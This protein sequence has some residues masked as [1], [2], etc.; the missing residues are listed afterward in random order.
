MYDVYKIRNDFPM[1]R[2]PQTMQGHPLVFL[3]NASTTFKPDRVLDAMDVYN[4]KETA[5]SHRG[6]YDLCNK[7]DRA[8]AKARESVARFL[9][10]GVNEIVFTAGATSALNLVAYGYCLKVLKPGDEILISLAEHASNVLP[11]FRIAS[12][13][14][15]K[16]K[17]IPL[18]EG[19]RITVEAVKTALTPHT[20]FV[21]VAYVGN[22]LGYIAPIKEIA[23]LAHA[24]GAVL[25]VDGA[26]STPHLKTDVKD[27]D[28]DFLAFSGHK[29]C[30]PTGTGALYGKY[31]LLCAMDP[32]ETGGGMNVKFYPDGT[33]TYL[34]PPMKFEA[35]TL[36]VAGIIGLG[37]AVEYVSSIGLEE[38]SAHEHM[39]KAYAV[40]KLLATGMVDIY[41]AD[42][43]GGIVTFNV[44]GVFSQDFATYL[45]AQGIACRS[46]QHCAKMLND[47]LCVPAT[48]RASFYLYTTKEEID[49]LVEA[50]KH[51]G[52]FLDAYF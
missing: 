43:E 8:V 48:V 51:G 37:E 42:S 34:L 12:L 15:A 18:S 46:G 31:D 3:D 16:V 7:A 52:N 33:A 39:L 24:N 23:A 6:D 9:N 10:A 4:R 5:N 49:A 25:C 28:C 38:I 41:N 50:V 44:H 14:G 11:W 26:Q 47:V 17:Y 30:A 22:V 1:L 45:N 32:F 29:F 19:N 27:L 13:T 21:S 36:N 40:E 35:G 20:K 2:E